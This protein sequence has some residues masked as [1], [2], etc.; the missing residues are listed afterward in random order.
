MFIVF[1]AFSIIFV[2]FHRLSSALM[3]FNV[4]RGMDALRLKEGLAAPTETFARF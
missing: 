2:D 3:D 1:D 4:F